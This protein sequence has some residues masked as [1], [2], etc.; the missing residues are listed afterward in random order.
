MK[1]YLTLVPHSYYI[2]SKHPFG[3]WEA[4][5]EF[6]TTDEA[7]D[8]AMKQMDRD[9]PPHS[10]QLFKIVDD[11]GGV[12]ILTDIFEPADLDDVA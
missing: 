9:D 7:Y 5:G 6:N 11:G 8:A 12:F 3:R 4:I 2:I 10:L 1:Y